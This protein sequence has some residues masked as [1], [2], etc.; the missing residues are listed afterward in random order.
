[1]RWTSERAILEELERLNDESGA[2]AAEYLGLAVDSAETE[3]AHKALRAQRLLLARANGVKSIA[4]ADAVAEAD[5]DVADAHLARLVAA[6]RADACR[7][8]L[9]TIRTNQDSL[10]TAAASHRT[11]FQGP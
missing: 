2:R 10:R 6:A 5:A 8:A 7:E 9:R 4:E 11:P 3:A 1:M